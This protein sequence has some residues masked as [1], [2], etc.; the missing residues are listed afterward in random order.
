MLTKCHIM[1]KILLHFYFLE[2]CIFNVKTLTKI[3]NWVEIHFWYVLL[4]SDSKPDCRNNYLVHSYR[5][6]YHLF[7]WSEWTETGGIQQIVKAIY[8]LLT[9]KCKKASSI[10]PTSMKFLRLSI[11]DTHTIP[12]AY[13][14]TQLIQEIFNSKLWSFSICKMQV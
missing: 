7:Y 3:E 1:F 8:L 14:F 11:H 5:K 9:K 2:G 6:P 12:R 13:I 10:Y 4:W